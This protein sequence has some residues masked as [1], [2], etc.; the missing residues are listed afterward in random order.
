MVRITPDKDWEPAFREGITL[1]SDNPDDCKALF[2]MVMQDLYQ[3]KISSENFELIIALG[4][5]LGGQPPSLAYYCTLSCQ[6]EFAKDDT[7]RCKKCDHPD[8][9]TFPTGKSYCKECIKSFFV[10]G[11]GMNKCPEGKIILEGLETAFKIPKL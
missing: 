7:I 1:P 4:R 2:S 10:E 3:K 8:T 5:Q 9:W 11:D 6:R